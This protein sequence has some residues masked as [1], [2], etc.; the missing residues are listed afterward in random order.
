MTTTAESPRTGKMSKHCITALAVMGAIMMGCNK[1]ATEKEVS[2]TATI[3]LDGSANSKALTA[4]GIKTFAEND[5]IAVIYKDAYGQTQKALSSKLQSTDIHEEGKKADFT[6]TLD[7]PAENGTL[8][9]IYPAAMAQETIATGATI[10]DAGTIDFTHL[11]AQDGT[12]S[13]LASQYDLAVYDGT[14]TAEA[15]LPA[16]VTLENQLA[17]GEFTVKNA[18][19]SV[20]INSS[21]TSLTISDGTNTYTVTRSA[22]EGPIYVAMKPVTD[23]KTL[24]FSINSNPTPKEVTGKALTAGDMYP[25]GL[26]F[27]SSINLTNVLTTDTNN[28]LYYEAQNGDIL[29]STGS[30]NGYV[31]IADGAQV[32]LN[33]RNDY[34][35]IAPFSCDHAAIHCLGNANIILADGMQGR[36]CSGFSSNYPA[37]FVP[38]DKTLTISGTGS[39]IADAD[40]ANYAAGIGG[41]YK[42]DC[43]SIVI[44]GGVIQAFGSDFGA[45]IGSGYFA[46]CDGIIIS[47]GVVTQAVGGQYAA[48][49]G[50][51]NAGS[52]GNIVISGGQIGGRYVN[53]FYYGAIGGERAAGIGC[54]NSDSSCGDITIGA[55]ITY[56]VAKMGEAGYQHIG[57]S[58]SSTCGTITIAKGLTNHEA[59]YM[60]SIFPSN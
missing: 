25:V 16:S 22:D 42:I 30:F 1:P 53:W 18:D 3:S 32:T 21:I 56:V 26:K 49:I 58:N 13:T 46:S 28:Q 9:Y 43:G 20:N 11:N 8:R 36:A 51:G 48:G 10:D 44:A 34:E 41:G 59:V 55:G 4:D 19:G 47:G 2:L 33:L 45:G 17:I 37:V 54:G 5:Q 38:K 24:T 57:E 27:G 52:C 6:V 31:T 7:Q 14:L 12:L 29:S 50:S 35:I 40:P 23:D 15:K 39:L 60:Q